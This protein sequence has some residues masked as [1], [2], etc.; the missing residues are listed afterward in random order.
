LE[1]FMPVYDICYLNQGGNLT[2]KFSA[3]CED[4]MR[5]KVLAHAM[6]QADFK[7]FEVWSGE[8]LVYPRPQHPH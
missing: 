8:S 6:K 1:D 3:I 4:N 2:Y 7:R 5:A